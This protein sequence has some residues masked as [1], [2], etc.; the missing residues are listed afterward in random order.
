MNRCQHN[1]LCVPID[2]RIDLNGFN[3]FCSDDYS[4]NKCENKNNQIDININK[5]IIHYY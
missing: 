5:I 3:C 1:G 2:N 4:G